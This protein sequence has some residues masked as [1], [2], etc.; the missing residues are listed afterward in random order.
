MHT[1]STME[2]EYEAFLQSEDR[3][4]RIGDMKFHKII[5][6]DRVAFQGGT[7]IITVP[8]ALF[9]GDMPKILMDE[10]GK[11][12]SLGSVCRMNFRGQIPKWYLNAVAVTVDGI[13][14]VTEIGNYLTVRKLPVTLAS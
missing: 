6:K 9:H 13:H 11:T 7:V 14:D 10:K 4:L 1:R 12:F 2:Q 3:V 8:H 5:H